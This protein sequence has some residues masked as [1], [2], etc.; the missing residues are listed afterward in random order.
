VQQEKRVIQ[1]LLEE[2]AKLAALESQEKLVLLV[3]PECL[4]LQVSQVRREILVNQGIPVILAA[5]A[6]AV[7]R[8]QP[9]SR[10]K[11]ESRGKQPTPVPRVKQVPREPLA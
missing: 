8:E 10:V 6:K 3:P 1:D 11:P 2:L 4:E 5:L 7:L 9:E